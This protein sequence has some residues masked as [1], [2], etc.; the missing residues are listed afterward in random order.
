MTRSMKKQKQKRDKKFRL[1]IIVLSYNTKDFLRACLESIEAAE[2]AGLE[3]QTIVVDNASSDGSVG[4]VEQEFSW[5]EL[6]RS[7]TNLG[8]SGGN[9]LGIKK[10]NGEYILFLN[11]DVELKKNALVD[12]VGFMNKDPDVGA[13]S[14]KVNLFSG[15]MDPDCHRGFPTPWASLSY[16]LGLE[17]IFPNSR[18]FGQYHKLYLDLD[19]PHEID[20]GFG[21]FM[22][23]RKKVVEEVGVWDES[24]FFYGEDL[25]YFYRIKN[26]GWKIMFY[27]KVLAI[28]HKGGSSGIRKESRQ[29]SPAS[30][31]TR[32]IT[33]RAS[34]SA[35]EIF[36][37]KFYEDRYS[38]LLTQIVL[39]GIRLKGLFRILKFKLV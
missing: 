26:A 33:A 23:I 15:G 37:K 3:L 24:Y 17:K 7:R 36:Y 32:I 19:E 14:P 30:K 10:A 28:H 39:L 13:M 31:E 11:S 4:M 25:D 21:T 6:V 2:K 38:P 34:I 18:L 35:W 1:S 16:F 12:S 20:A 8:Y 5:T 29:A 27:P 22:I 9:N